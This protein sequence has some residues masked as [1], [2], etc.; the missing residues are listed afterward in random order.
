[1]VEDRITVRSGHGVGKSCL[2][3]WII[4]HYML[5]R[6]PV[7]VAATAPTGH[8]LAD[9]LLPEI[10]YLTRRLPPGLKEQIIVKADRVELTAAPKE[11][12]LVART[13]RAESPEAL[14]GLHAEHMLY[15]I[16]EASIVPDIIFEVAQGAMSTPGA[17]TIMTGN[18][19]R[20]DGY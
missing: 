11:S 8:Q 18:P 14:Q 16:D 6:Y 10:A 15:V 9:V 4:I 5:T 7:K 13:A 3:A 19:N 20:P 2:L 12:F 1:A 17:K